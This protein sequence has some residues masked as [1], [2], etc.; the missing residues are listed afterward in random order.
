MSRVLR[1]AVVGDIAAIEAMQIAAY[2]A[3]RAL[4]GVTPLPL[5]ADYAEIFATF[6]IW[7]DVTSGAIDGALILQPR[8]EGLL[9]WSVAVAPQARS[10][11]VGNALLAKAEEVARAQG[12]AALV[13]YT[14]QP[15]VKNI[16][17]YERHGYVIT[18]TEH[19]PDRAIVHMKKQL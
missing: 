9:I 16:A 14:G 17:W 13:L 5:L 1:R 4:L 12:I 11:R 3:N 2:D 15:L 7:V 19:R 10:L 6:E 8:P 18:R